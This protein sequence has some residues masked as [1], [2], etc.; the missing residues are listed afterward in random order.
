M[1]LFSKIFKNPKQ[2]EVYKYFEGL[3]SYVPAFTTFNG[4]VY[5]MELTRAAIHAF[6]NACSKLKPEV[7]GSAYEN[8]KNILQFQPN[9]YMN[10]SRF[11]Y[12]LATMFSIKNNAFVAPM[13]DEGGRIAQGTTR[14]FLATPRYWR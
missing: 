7:H 11:L 6:A 2:Q 9:P 3:S 8:L 1:W 5:E 13:L 14:Y 12:R 10:T 4:G